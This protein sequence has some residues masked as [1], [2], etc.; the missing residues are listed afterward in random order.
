[1][2]KNE[3]LDNFSG[4]YC[5]VNDIMAYVTGLN[6]DTS[7]KTVL[8]N[9]NNLIQKG[10]VARFGRGVYGFTSKPTFIPYVSEEAKQTCMRIKQKFRYLELT[11]TDSSI[12]GQFMV[13][14]PFSS[15]IVIEVRKSAVN[16]VVSFLRNEG[17]DAY[18]KKDYKL[19]EKYILTPQPYIIRS[20]LIT[21]PNLKSENNVRYSSL[22]KI[23]V[24]I[25]CDDIVYSQ[26][27]DAELLNIYKNITNKYIINYSQMLKYAASRKRKSS[28]LALLDETTEFNKLRSLL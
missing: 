28:V 26:Y 20:E 24:D 1:M 13:L 3:I 17:I 5:N 21:N 14:Q 7:R 8:W 6:G 9:I 2:M 11:V 25:V 16:A 12:L 27:Q 23:L 19:I 4:K 22:E 10:Q 15:V 18:I